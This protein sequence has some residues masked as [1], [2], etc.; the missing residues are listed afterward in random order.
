MSICFSGTKGV[1]A[2]AVHILASDGAIDYDAPVAHYWPEFG[3]KGKDAITVRQ[4]LAHQAG[5]HKTV[6]LVDQLTD[7]LEWDRIVRRVAQP[8]SCANIHTNAAASASR[9]A[10]ATT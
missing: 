7:I 9:A 6:P 3:C 10:P 4:V 5:L 8:R 1:A 2:T